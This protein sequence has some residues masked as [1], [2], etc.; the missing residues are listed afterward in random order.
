MKFKKAEAY[1][2]QIRNFTRTDIY[3]LKNFTGMFQRL[4]EKLTTQ[5]NSIQ[6]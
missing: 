5:A 6:R 3:L 1:A 2:S 4:M